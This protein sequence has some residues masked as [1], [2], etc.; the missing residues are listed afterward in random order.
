[1]DCILW[2][3]HINVQGYG[4]VK[5]DGRNRGAHRVAWEAQ[6][7][8][9]PPG[10][11]IDH[12]C[13]VRACV[14]VQHLQPVSPRTNNLR[15]QGIAAVNSRKDACPAGHPYDDAN[16][17]VYEG[18]RYCRACHNARNAARK[19]NLRAAWRAAGVPR[20]Y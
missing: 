20:R 9:V 16:T 14:N 19:A 12:L 15:G 13:R 4:T 18:R 11:E 7:G 1:M 3:G 10:Q 6:H 2:T 17:R 8:P 5:V